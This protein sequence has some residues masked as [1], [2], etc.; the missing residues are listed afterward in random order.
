MLTKNLLN[1]QVDSIFNKKVCSH[2]K[3]KKSKI[4]ALC[5]ETIFCVFLKNDFLFLDKKMDIYFCPFFLSDAISFFEKNDNIQFA[6]LSTKICLDKFFITLLSSR[7]C[8]IPTSPSIFLII[9]IQ[10]SY[11]GWS[12]SR[13]S[14]FL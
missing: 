4:T 5:S 1:I 9:L 6:A 2:T 7:T 3:N 10:K 8:S 12:E 14:G 13:H 11:L